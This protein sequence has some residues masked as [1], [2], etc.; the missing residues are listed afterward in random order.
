MKFSV[1]DLEKLAKI[2]SG[3]SNVSWKLTSQAGDQQSA[4]FR[5]VCRDNVEYV[6]GV[7]LRLLVDVSTDSVM[8]TGYKIDSPVKTHT[9]VGSAIVI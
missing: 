8:I 5:V 6:Q 1:K 2:S 7:H 3:C 9:L 4:R